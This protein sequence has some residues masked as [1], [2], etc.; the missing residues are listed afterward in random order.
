MRLLANVLVRFIPPSHCRRPT[1]RS[2]YHKADIPRPFR[3]LDFH[4]HPSFLP[5]LR[6]A[7]LERRHSPPIHRQA[8]PTRPLQHHQARRGLPSHHISLPPFS[9]PSI[10]FG[11]RLARMRY[12]VSACAGVTW[13]NQNG[14]VTGQCP[15]DVLQRYPDDDNTELDD[16]EHSW[17][18]AEC[19]VVGEGGK[20]WAQALLFAVCSSQARAP[21]WS[22][23]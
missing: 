7:P 18:A 12:E 3:Y 8:T 21:A 2:L 20:V 4:T 16:D 14:I 22:C 11:N 9:P 13:K 15:V 6:P 10:D 5:G 17:P 1:H 23:K 19:L